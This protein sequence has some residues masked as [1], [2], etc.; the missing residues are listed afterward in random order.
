MKSRKKVIFVGKKGC[1]KTILFNCISGEVFNILYVPT[2]SQENC[3]KDISINGIK[4][5]K[6]SLLTSGKCV[7]K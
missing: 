3:Q 1:G 4:V 6:V 5:I 2:I 7:K